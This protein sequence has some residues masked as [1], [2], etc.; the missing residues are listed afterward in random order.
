MALVWTS[1]KSCLSAH[2]PRLTAKDFLLSRSCDTRTLGDDPA[3]D[4]RDVYALHF[5]RAKHSVTP[6]SAPSI[7]IWP[8]S[9]LP[10]TSPEIYNYTTPRIMLGSQLLLF[11]DLFITTGTGPVTPVPADFLAAIFRVPSHPNFPNHDTPSLLHS[12]SRQFPP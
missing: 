4:P 9:K 8:L 3:G 7:S 1:G 10:Y 12:R 11:Y 6:G 5:Y 2:L